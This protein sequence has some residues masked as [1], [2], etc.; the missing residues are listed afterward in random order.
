MGPWGHA[1]AQG[2]KPGGYAS[3]KHGTF[4]TGV[5]RFYLQ[6]HPR[7]TFLH[8]TVRASNAPAV[9]RSRSWTPS[10]SSNHSS[11]HSVPSGTLT[12]RSVR[13]CGWL[14][15]LKMGKDKKETM[16]LSSPDFLLEDL[17]DLLN[18][19]PR[20]SVFVVWVPKSFKEN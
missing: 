19:E 16:W 6:S 12:S 13:N 5:P 10:T 2:P 11:E 18:L 7:N 3:I 9:T 14:K 4:L 8:V 1:P 17:D 15:I 20:S